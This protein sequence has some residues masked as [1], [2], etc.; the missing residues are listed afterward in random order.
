MNRSWNQQLREQLAVE[1]I[2]QKEAARNQLRERQERE[3]Q[4]RERLAVSLYTSGLFCYD[5]G[6]LAFFVCRC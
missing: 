6:K 5:D 1:E 3:R 4:E 2:A